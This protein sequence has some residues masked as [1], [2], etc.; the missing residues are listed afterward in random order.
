MFYLLFI[1][2]NTWMVFRLHDK[3]WDRFDIITDFYNQNFWAFHLL[4]NVLLLLFFQ[5]RLLAKFSIH[6][7]IIDCSDLND[8]EAE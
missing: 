4:Q 3:I 8:K 5:W 7:F 6:G 1:L 2:N